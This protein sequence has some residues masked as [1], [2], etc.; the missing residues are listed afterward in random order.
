MAASRLRLPFI[1]ASVDVE[2]AHGKSPFEQMILGRCD[3]GQN[4]GTFQIAQALEDIGST[5][6]FFVDIYEDVL[7]GTHRM[8]TLC[9]DL[10]ARGHDVQ[11]HTHPSWRIDPRDSSDLNDFKASRSRFP[12][13]KD[14][15]TKLTLDEQIAFIKEGKM[16]LENWLDRPVL[17]HRSGGYSINDDTIAALRANNIMIDSSMNGSHTNSK[18]NWSKNR[19]VERDGM[20]ELPVTYYRLLISKHVPRVFHA[21]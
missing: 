16:M 21:Y 5:G 18:I 8:K 17:A 15:M 1:F 20:L 9:Q 11:L 14:F 2:A 4:W 7:W 12:P 10:T 6:T 13:E 19:I 3:N